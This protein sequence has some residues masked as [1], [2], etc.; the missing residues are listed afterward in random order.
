[1]T[2]LLPALVGG[3]GFALGRGGEWVRRTFGVDA[4]RVLLVVGLPLG[5]APWFLHLRIIRWELLYGWRGLSDDVTARVAA[6]VSTFTVHSFVLAAVLFVLG[7]VSVWRAPLLVSGFP[8]LLDF[9]YYLIPMGGLFD[10]L[11]GTDV[12]TDNVPTI[13]LA[14]LSC[15]ASAGLFGYVL[16]DAGAW[17]HPTVRAT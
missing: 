10:A 14:W 16:G 4:S 6:A 17:V 1:M 11:G 15:A 12:T 8:L 7:L 13:W 9:L 2:L 5:F 3:V